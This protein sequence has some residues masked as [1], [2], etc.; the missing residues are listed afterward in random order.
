MQQTERKYPKKQKFMKRGT[1]IPFCTR[2]DKLYTVCTRYMVEGGPGENNDR[3]NDK[4]EK[5][6]AK[7][8]GKGLIATN[9]ICLS[10]CVSPEQCISG[11]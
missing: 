2:V 8:G 4:R 9:R 1:I 3:V 7:F 6:Q 5:A 10:P 11:G